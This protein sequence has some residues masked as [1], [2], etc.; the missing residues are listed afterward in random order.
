MATPIRDY[1]KKS[2]VDSK[3]NA[4]QDT[5]TF[6][7]SPR[8]NS[9]NPVKS[10]GIKSYVDSA[11]AGVSQFKYEIVDELPTASA[12]TMGKIY[13]ILAQDRD[14]EADTDNYN[15]WITVEENLINYRW[16]LIG[17]T[18]VDLSN[19]VTTNTKQNISEN[20]TFS[21]DKGIGLAYIESND[22]DQS[23]ANGW[24]VYF[25]E[26]Q[27][28]KISCGD[29]A[30]FIGDRE[31][32]I[33]FDNDTHTITLPTDISEDKEIA[34][35]SDVYTYKVETSPSTAS[36]ISF[37]E[38]NLATSKTETLKTIYLNTVNGNRI[39]GTNT[40]VDIVTPKSWKHTYYCEVTVSGTNYMKFFIEDVRNDNTAYTSLSDLVNRLVWL[41]SAG[42]GT[43]GVVAKRIPIK[44]FW[45]LNGDV[46][47]LSHIEGYTI[48][49][50]PAHTTSST[51][52]ASDY[53]I[54]NI[55]GYKDEPWEL[56]NSKES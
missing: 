33:Y 4:K 43:S 47:E 32:G 15:E 2:E 53:S 38:T 7:D 26:G 19:Y 28:T 29:N 8:L 44:G 17:D 35:T 3:L 42:G 37:T 50:S 5:L 22:V 51:F 10:S 14:Q 6:D 31:N 49:V 18:R 56:S 46:F 27:A 11:I 21:K 41:T 55:T 36:Y 1:Y 30:L 45:Y 20:K 16:E 25:N 39:L 52:I 13:L 48:Y 12:D 34:F 9:S 24:G 40:S 54:S 23:Y